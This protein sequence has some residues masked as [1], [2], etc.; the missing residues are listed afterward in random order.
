MTPITK[1]C[2]MMQE[3]DVIAARDVSADYIGFVLA[4]SRRQVTPEQVETWRQAV[5]DAPKPVLVLVDEDEETIVSLCQQTG[6]NHVQ[7]CG[8]ETP[9]LCNTLRVRHQLTVWKAWGVYGDERDREIMTYAESVDAILLDKKAPGQA[10]GTGKAF[11]WDAIGSI[12]AYC[13]TLPLIVAGGLTPENVATLLQSIE[14]DGVDVS[15]GIE[16]N[17]QKDSVKIERFVD[18]VR[19]AT[20]DQSST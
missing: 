15:S 19:R 13:P 14:V 4:K 10:G 8:E 11:S 5:P 16:T 20:Y 12:K 3:R 18:E 7:L 1:L 2:G 9:A 6:V 17:G